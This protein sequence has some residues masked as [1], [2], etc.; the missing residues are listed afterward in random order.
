MTMLRS[1]ACHLFCL[2]RI[3]VLDR[4]LL[5]TGTLPWYHVTS[6]FHGSKIS[7]KYASTT[8]KFPFSFC[9][10]K[11]LRYCLNLDTVLS[12]LTPEKFRCH[13]TDYMKLNKVVEV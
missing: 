2:H 10:Q 11:K 6:R 9:K 3:A 1:V 5:E 7:T 13:L 12:D 8:Q 4:F